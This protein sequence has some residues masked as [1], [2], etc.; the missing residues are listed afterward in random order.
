MKF[1]LSVIFFFV[2]HVIVSA[3]FIY[4]PFPLSQTDFAKINQLKY[5]KCLV[6]KIENGEKYLVKE[7]E[8]GNMGLL[9]NIYEKGTNDNGDSINISET[10]YKYDGKGKLTRITNVDEES[11]E[12]I[13]SFTYD[14]GGRLTIKRV[15]TIDPPTY[16][17]K[18]DSKGRISEARVTQ[19]MPGMDSE[20]NFTGKSIE[21]PA[22][23]QIFKYN[24]KGQLA[25]ESV[26]NIRNK[27]P[28]FEYKYVWVYDGQ[29]R[30]IEYKRTDADGNTL[31]KS[32]FEYNREGLLSK[33]V[34]SN[35]DDVTE[36]VFL[37]EYNREKQS[38]K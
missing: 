1:I 25:E 5:T 13:T 26:Y 17:Y 27:E 2:F 38:W 12:V 28:E 19:L 30:V 32:R 16:S 24:I 10:V 23:R 21:V 22:L 29:G 18:Y 33:S 11:G 15:V 9:S 37:Y 35:D 4:S 8:Y 7:A 34:E 36:E 31:N 14:P 20:G 6:F 3:Q